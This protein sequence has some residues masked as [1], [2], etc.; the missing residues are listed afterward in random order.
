MAENT[1]NWGGARK[2]AG[3]PKGTTKAESNQ[4]KQRNMRAHDNEWSLIKRFDAIIKAGYIVECEKFLTEIES[5]D[6]EQ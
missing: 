4:R 2:G 5:R 1:N 6:I 3:R